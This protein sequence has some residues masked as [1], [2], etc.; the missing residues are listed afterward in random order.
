MTMFALIYYLY[1]ELIDSCMYMQ[2]L[3]RV[4]FCFL[5]QILNPRLTCFVGRRKQLISIGIYVIES[6][7]EGLSDSHVGWTTHMSMLMTQNG[8]NQKFRQKPYS[9]QKQVFVLMRCYKQKQYNDQIYI[10]AHALICKDLRGRVVDGAG[11]SNSRTGWTKF[12]LSIIQDGP[13]RMDQTKNLGGNLALFRNKYR[14]RQT[15]MCACY[16]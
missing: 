2:F 8:S 4:R 7:M 1:L 14:Y 9:F 3:N 13:N 6:W 16:G 5:G 12:Y 11:Q 15:N 10:G